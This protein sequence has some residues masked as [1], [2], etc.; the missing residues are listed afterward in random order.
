MTNS[1]GWN[2]PAANIGKRQRIRKWRPAVRPGCRGW[3]EM[4][5]KWYAIIGQ[6]PGKPEA[7]VIWYGQSTLD[8][9]RKKAKAMATGNLVIVL[10]EVIEF[11]V[12]SS[13]LSATSNDW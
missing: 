12:K 4:D 8:E 11:N 7:L 2:A 5:E 9:A 13:P 3:S 10:A 6:S 1:N